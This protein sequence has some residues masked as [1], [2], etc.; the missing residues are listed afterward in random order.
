[1]LRFEYTAS[2]WSDE[3]TTSSLWNHII[4][5]YIARRRAAVGDPHSPVLVLT[6]AFAT[7]WTPR[8]R[9]VVASADCINYIVIPD[10]L[11]HLFQPL[12]LGIIAAIKNSLQRRKDDFLEEEVA[13]AIRENRG[14]VLRK[15]RP[16]LRNKI[17]M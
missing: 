6:D 1:M 4:L 5:P 17:T 14:V 16:V 2:H 13:T 9:A 3:S 12:D 7:H 10:S 15:S 8:V 11:T